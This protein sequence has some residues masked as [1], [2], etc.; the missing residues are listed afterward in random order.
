[1]ARG[2]EFHE[3]VQGDLFL[4]HFKDSV[5]APQVAMTPDSKGGI[6]FLAR[7]RTPTGV[8]TTA[9]RQGSSGYR[10]VGYLAARVHPE[11][12]PAMEITDISV[13]QSER[14]RGIGASLFHFSRQFDDIRHSM[15]RTESGSAWARKV[16]GLDIFGRDV[17]SYGSRGK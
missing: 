15:A 8:A 12:D 13:D 2:A 14:G 1:M 5:G 6:T 4:D 3:G 17:R 16:G 10:D 7:D 11:V 9:Y